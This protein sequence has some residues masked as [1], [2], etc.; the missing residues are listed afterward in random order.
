MP[1]RKATELTDLIKKL[2]TIR[3]QHEV[4]LAEI[5]ATFR[6]FG[7]EHLL[8]GTG[9]R[10]RGAAAKGKGKAKAK[11]AAAAAAAPAKGKGKRKG[12][13]RGRPPKAATAAAAPKTRKTRKRRGAKAKKGPK[14]AAAG[15]G[16]RRTRAKYAQTGDEFILAFIGKKGTAT[17]NEIR[18]HW[19]KAGRKGK[20]ENNLTGLV[21]H[22]KVLR[23][24]TP[25]EAGSTY[26]LPGSATPPPAPTT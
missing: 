11:A 25:G 6:Q 23:T 21:K 12:K 26:A 10:K 4:A 5:E 22:G 9:S 1:A 18:Q 19:K 7:I 16:T 13:R 2:R 20:A 14:A 8:E 17:T 3:R 24:P 15:T